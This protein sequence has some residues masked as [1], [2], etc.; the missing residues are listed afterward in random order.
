MITAVDSAVDFVL[1][2]PIPRSKGRV[3]RDE[4]YGR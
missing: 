1:T 4:D 3:S 2:A